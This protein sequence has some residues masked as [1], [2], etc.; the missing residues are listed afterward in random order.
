MWSSNKTSR[1]GGR[2]RRLGIGYEAVKA[3]NPKNRLRERVGV[4]AERAVCRVGPAN[5]PI[6]QAVAG[7]MDMTGEGGR[8]FPC[9]SVLR[10]PTF[11][12]AALARRFGISGGAFLHLERHRR[13]AAHLITSLLSAATFQHDSPA[14]AK[15]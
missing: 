5:D 13:W 10:C 6:V 9:G 14:T 4:W 3:R 15:R 1:A 2:S 12:A 7:L 8:Q 11:G